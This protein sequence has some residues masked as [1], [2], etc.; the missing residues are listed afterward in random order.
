[1]G[2]GLAIYI[3]GAGGLESLAYKIWHLES[4]AL[5]YQA[6]VVFEET[7]EMVGASMIFYGLLLVGHRIL[8]PQTQPAVRPEP[9]AY[10]RE[11]FESQT[12]SKRAG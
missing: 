5:S 8:A 1:M 7:M 3:I 2:L 6:E 4:T 12:T 9:G 10:P 11:L